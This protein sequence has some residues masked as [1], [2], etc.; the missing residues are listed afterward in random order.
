MAQAIELHMWP[1]PNGLKISLALREMGL[2]YTVV[3]VNIAIGDQ[4]KPEF[5]ALSPNGRMPAIVD[6]DSADGK[7]L[8][9][10]ES[11]AILQHLGRKS[12]RFY[13]QH[14]RGRAEVEQ[15]LFWQVGGLGPM[16]G[17]ANHFRAY[18]PSFIRDQ[19]M[20]AYPVNR[21]TNEVNR[22]WGVVDKRLRD[23]DF[24]AGDYPIA[25][26][27]CW[28]W[29]RAPAGHGID[30]AEFPRAE[31]WRQRIAARP[32]A[33]EAVAEGDALRTASPLTQTG[34]EA[35]KARDLLFGQRARK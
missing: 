25:D 31:A 17:Q 35:D 19:R 32:A 3:P 2:P 7:P 29:M 12:G 16:A 26:M 18:G 8:S 11:G 33:V 1:T 4:F 20:L 15:W 24:L 34:A 27:A 23:R 28:P 30:V 14:E 13:P 10:F 5:Q 22:L 9:I 21:Y 6:H